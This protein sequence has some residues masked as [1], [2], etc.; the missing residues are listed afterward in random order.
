VIF[1]ILGLI[2]QHKNANGKSRPTNTSG[3]QQQQR[4]KM[5]QF[6]RSKPVGN[7]L[8]AGNTLLPSSS[9]RVFVKP[10]AA[11]HIIPKHHP[12]NI[13]VPT[14]GDT[15][16]I[17]SFS[18]PNVIKPKT[19]LINPNFKKIS[20][21]EMN[22]DTKNNLS[23]IEGSHNETKSINISTTVDISTSP[24]PRPTTI[25]VNPNF[26]GTLKPPSIHINSKVF[27]KKEAELKVQQKPSLDQPTQSNVNLT[28]K[29][30]PGNKYTIKTNR[31][32][33][34]QK[35]KESPTCLKSTL[36]PTQKQNPLVCVNKRKL[37]RLSPKSTKL[38]Q[39]RKL[40][41]QVR[42]PYQYNKDQLFKSPTVVRNRNYLVKRLKLKS[43]KK[44]QQTSTYKF[45]K[46]SKTKST[47]SSTGVSK[48]KL[49]NRKPTVQLS[50]KSPRKTT[51]P[52]EAK[53]KYSWRRSSVPQGLI[54]NKIYRYR[55][56]STSSQGRL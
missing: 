24:D 35:S 4:S 14:K 49:D 5:Y 22:S 38:I 52:F 55:K 32:L 3:V 33:V 43:P 20:K 47:K 42:N 25:L 19:I 54:P 8:S 1:Y 53:K 41:L 16:H 17:R 15:P 10:S 28:A 45:V 37:V 26:K 30:S 13:P 31:K 48:F 36:L 23:S 27:N 12:S 34:R 9:T 46:N 11:S 6:I 7:S 21:P 29:P 50:T 56:Y 40:N 2:N 51:S 44:I 18:T 39:S